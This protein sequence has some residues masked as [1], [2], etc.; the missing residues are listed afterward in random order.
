MRD[1]PLHPPSFVATKD[2]PEK[3]MMKI[4]KEG[5]NN[6]SYVLLVCIFGCI[7]GAFAS[8]SSIMSFLFSFYN[9]PGEPKIYSNSL[10][11]L[12][13]ACVSIVGVLSSLAAGAYL[14]KTQKY[15][16]TTRLI[17]VMV[18]LMVAAAIFTVPSGNH[19]VVGVN[20]VLLGIFMVPII[21]V[22]MNFASEMTFP[23]APAMT[24]GWLLMIGYAMGAVLAILCTPLSQYSPRLVMLIYTFLG[25]VACICSIFLK[26][27]LKKTEFAKKNVATALCDSSEKLTASM[28]SFKI[29]T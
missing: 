4:F 2:D 8:F 26:E 5:F 24:N 17:C 21:P 29:E 28:D 19:I 27:D 3:K 10:I 12:Y 7:D 18:T 22:S 14:Q 11:S 9:V 6:R 16:L 20:L 13:G 1:K 23:L 25:L 15:L